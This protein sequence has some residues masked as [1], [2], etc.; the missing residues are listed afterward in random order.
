[1]EIN[2]LNEII[3][4]NNSSFF[5]FKSIAL[6]FDEKTCV[7]YIIVP[8]IIAISAEIEGLIRAYITTK[9]GT[10]NEFNPLAKDTLKKSTP[11]VILFSLLN[12]YESLITTFRL[13]NIIY[14][15]K[16]IFYSFSC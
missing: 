15:F 10:R 2:V 13:F 14:F 9:K 11:A 16:F 6:L 4:I 8:S 3:F 5:S 1:M 12:F 7:K